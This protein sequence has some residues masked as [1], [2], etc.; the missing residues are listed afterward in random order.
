MA[1]LAYRQRTFYSA[2]KVRF[3]APLRWIKP[4]SFTW[5]WITDAPQ[6]ATFSPKS[7][8]NQ[9]QPFSRLFLKRR[10]PHS[11]GLAGVQDFHGFFK[12]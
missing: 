10:M 12:L 8:W 4:N 6:V 11:I 1:R 3:I 2:P 5:T 9:F 7:L